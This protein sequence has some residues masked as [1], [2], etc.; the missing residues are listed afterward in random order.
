MSTCKVLTYIVI[1]CS[2]FT[3]YRCK[4][5]GFVNFVTRNSFF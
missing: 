4:G 3:T 2:A 5:F 1:S